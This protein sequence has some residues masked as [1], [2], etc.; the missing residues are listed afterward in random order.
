LIISHHN[1]GKMG[2]D[3]NGGDQKKGGDQKGGDQKKGG[4]QNGGDQKK[5][6]DQNGGDQKKGGDMKK[7]QGP[8]Q[9][10]EPLHVTLCNIYD[11][12]Q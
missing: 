1:A 6:G 4:D 10:G 12:V 3:Q 7:D 2:G 9:G 5:G 8:P 11:A